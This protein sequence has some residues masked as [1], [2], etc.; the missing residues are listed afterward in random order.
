MG[1]RVKGANGKGVVVGARRSPANH[2]TQYWIQK[3]KDE[4]FW[5]TLE[6]VK[7]M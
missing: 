4:R 6:E 7:P 1:A 2:I 3:T 5:A